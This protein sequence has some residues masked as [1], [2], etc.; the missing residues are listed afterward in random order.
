MFARRRGERE[1]KKRNE[2]R[3]AEIENHYQLSLGTSLLLRRA[4]SFRGVAQPTLERRHVAA[5]AAAAATAA[6]AAT[7]RTKGRKS[8]WVKGS[9]N[10]GA[11]GGRFSPLVW[12][13]YVHSLTRQWKIKSRVSFYQLFDQP[14]SWMIIDRTKKEKSYWK[15]KTSNEKTKKKKTDEKTIR[16]QRAR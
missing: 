12:V 5:T 3:P 7:S 1:G 10:G 14:T 6:I 16:K 13:S 8:I 11:R 15:K 2:E 9:R 4:P